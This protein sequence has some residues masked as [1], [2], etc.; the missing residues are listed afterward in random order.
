MRGGLPPQSE[1]ER[2]H[3]RVVP[4]P[5]LVIALAKSDLTKPEPPVEG[6]GRGVVAAHLEEEALCS[7]ALGGVREGRDEPAGNTMAAVS[8]M[9]AEREKLCLIGSEPPED[10]ADRLRRGRDARQKRGRTRL[11]QQLPEA[12]FIP[13]LGKEQ[14]VQL[15]KLP[16]VPLRRLLEQ[17]VGVTERRNHGQLWRRTGSAGGFTSGGLR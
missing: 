12:R 3:E 16:G 6:N 8:L 14:G 11:S 17:R 10:E 4:L 7:T 2:Q 5:V 1:P 13:G 9:H 15:G